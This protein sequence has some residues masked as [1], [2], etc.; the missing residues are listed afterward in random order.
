MLTLI[1]A[2]PTAVEA[3]RPPHGYT[4]R[5]CRQSDIP[6]LGHL[7]F[8]SYDPGVA[9]ATLAEAIADIEAAF[10]GAYG[11]LWQEASQVAV[12]PD[13]Q[14]VSAIQIVRRAPWEDTPDCPFITELFT[15]RSHR[16][17]GLARALVQS[18]MAVLAG[19]EH[20]NVALR[21]DEDNTPA[22]ILYESLGFHA[23]ARMHREQL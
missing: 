20:A 13:E 9:C 21:V 4:L 19:A 3:P 1:A 10:A 22:L 5:P 7:Y 6:D 14:P 8:E 17:R 16:R 18:S 15:A 11:E 2:I 12:A 23:W